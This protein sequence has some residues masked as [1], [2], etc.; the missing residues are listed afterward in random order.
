MDYARCGSAET[1]SFWLH[2][3]HGEHGGYRAE[4]ALAGAQRADVAILGG[5]FTGL[6]TAWHLKQ[7][8]PSLNVAVL[9]GAVIGY[10]ASGRNGGFSMTLFG[11]EPDITT[12]LFG[13]ERAREAHRYM[14][15]AVDYVQELVR[16]QGMACD[17]EHNGFARV[18]LTPAHERRLQRQ[19]TLYDKWGFA[20]SFH[21]WDRGQMQQAVHSPLFQGGFFEP[22]CGI[23]NPARQVL[24]WKRLCLETGVK[25]FEHSAAQRLSYGNT[26]ATLHTEAGSLT[27]ERVV[28]ATNAYSHLLPDMGHFSRRQ[29]PVWTYQVVTEPLTDA[30]WQAIGWQQ[31]F[32]IETN[33]HMV[34][35][36]RPTADGR[37]TFGGANVQLA[38]GRSMNHDQHPPTWA[39]LEQHLK[40]LFPPLKDVAIAFRWGGPVSVTMDMVPNLGFY[41]DKRTLYLAGCTGHGVSLTQYS[42]LTLAE[43]ALGLDS[44]RTDA[45]FVSRKPLAWPPEPLRFLGGQAIRG[46]LRAEDAWHERGLWGQ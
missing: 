33:R 26:T 36:F 7:L 5:G 16:T 42:G 8:D 21:W 37:I 28:L 46:L 31:R 13:L 1:R 45:W 11:F 3:E 17:Y 40:S 14:E 29:A 39:M 15:D 44:P 25:I 43:L 9:E 41:R 34:H 12:T 30:Q 2:D 23:L 6:S 32:G 35:Y 4:P 19:L 24:E 18:A 38:Y 10:G 20:D 27:A 22:R